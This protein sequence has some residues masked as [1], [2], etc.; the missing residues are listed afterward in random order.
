M[1]PSAGLMPHSHTSRLAMSV[2]ATMS[3][4]APVVSRP[5]TSDSAARPPSRMVMRL[6]R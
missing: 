5:N 6:T 4:L 2:A 1:G 3:L